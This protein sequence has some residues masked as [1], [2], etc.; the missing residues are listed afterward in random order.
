MHT[1]EDFHGR[2]LQITTHEKKGKWSEPNLQGIMWTSRSST[3][4]YVTY[5]DFTEIRLAFGGVKMLPNHLL[6]E[7]ETTIDIM[8]HQP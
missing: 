3:G 2:N 6:W 1:L 4:G 5:L 7:P 8:L